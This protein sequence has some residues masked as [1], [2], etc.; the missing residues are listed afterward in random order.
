MIN[1]FRAVNVKAD[2]DPALVAR[3][4]V[5]GV[6]S[7]AVIHSDEFFMDVIAGGWP[8]DVSV[9]M[10]ANSTTDNTVGAKAT[11]RVGESMVA[12]GLGEFYLMELY[13]WH[14]TQEV[15]ILFIPEPA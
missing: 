1:P 4:T 11:L 3:G 6:S 5:Y 7:G 2:L 15:R 9:D 10:H 12:P 8:W 13:E 14:G